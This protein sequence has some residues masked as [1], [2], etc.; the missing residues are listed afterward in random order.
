MADWVWEAKKI[1]VRMTHQGQLLLVSTAQC[2]A[3]L[4]H[5]TMMAEAVDK[6]RGSAETY[7]L[8]SVRF[9]QHKMF[10]ATPQ[11]KKKKKNFPPTNK[12]EI[13]EQSVLWHTY[14]QHPVE[15][16]S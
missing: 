10:W 16:I 5:A 11:L 2:E 15:V 8:R 6:G 12:R 7:K 13:Q 9:M 1:I 4:H 14:S 3:H